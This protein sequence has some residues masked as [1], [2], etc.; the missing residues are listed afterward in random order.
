MFHWGYQYPIEQNVNID[1][2]TAADPKIIFWRPTSA[3]VA[4]KYFNQDYNKA[5]VQSH[6]SP[7]RAGQAN[8][9]M[10][11]KRAAIRN[12]WRALLRT[13]DFPTN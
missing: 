13:V 4:Y 7:R 11:V 6:S 1:T 12:I 9:V 2:V 5:R 10:Y 3:E 8:I